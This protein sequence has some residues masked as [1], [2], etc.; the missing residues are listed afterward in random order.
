MRNTVKTGKGSSINQTIQ[1]GAS[2]SEILE[3]FSSVT[4][5]KITPYM[6]TLNN[7]DDIQKILADNPQYAIPIIWHGSNVECELLVKEN[8]IHPSVLYV[9]T[10]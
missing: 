2:I 10:N 3:A 9:T 1:N 7:L 6:N 8:K 5:Q 4:E